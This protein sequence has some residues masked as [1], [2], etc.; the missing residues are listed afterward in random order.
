[1]K[2]CFKCYEKK[3][4]SEFY[5]HK[6]MG[7]GYLGKCKVCTKKDTKERE[8]KLREDPDWC[9]KE[10]VRHNEKYH[11]LN[12]KVNSR[13]NV[14]KRKQN[15]TYKKPVVDPCKK[16]NN[17]ERYNNKFPEKARARSLSG[18]IVSK[19]KGNQLHH[20]SYNICDAK[21]LI[22][23]SVS[24]HGK[25]HRFMEYD[26]SKMV[27]RTLNGEL[28]DTKEKHWNYWLTIKDLK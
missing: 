28:L 24:D 9:E 23:L 21:D 25:I 11:R 5:K 20:W 2:V 18:N 16:K 13:E 4:L 19:V 15:G 8:V 12:Y 26:Q 17:I 1:M 3:P 14:L 6:G 27:Y 7:D 22:E 10:R